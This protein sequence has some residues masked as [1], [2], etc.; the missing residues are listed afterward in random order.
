M[1]VST[2]LFLWYEEPALFFILLVAAGCAVAIGWLKR[3]RG[4]LLGG[5]VGLVIVVAMS[6]LLLTVA[7]G[8]GRTEVEIRVKVV[9]ADTRRPISFARVEIEGA[10]FGASLSSST[11]SNSN[12]IAWFID[13]FPWSTRKGLLIERDFIYAGG[14]VLRVEADG[15]RPVEAMFDAYTNATWPSKTVIAPDI[16]VPL[17]RAGLADTPTSMPE[18]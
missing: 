12:G 6:P 10:A 18:R 4:L 1:A 17:E 5:I 2:Q 14:H 8:N 11:L 3:R 7:F 13:E 15:Y 16:V 9:D